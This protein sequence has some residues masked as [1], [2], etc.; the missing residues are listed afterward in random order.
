M[1]ETKSRKISKAE[2]AA[3]L[4]SLRRKRLFFWAVIAIYLPMIWVVLK[5]FHSDKI[6]GMFFG[7]WLVFLVVAVIVSAFA[8]C[9]GCG[10][11]FHM[12]G[13]MPLYLRNCHHCGMHVS[14]DEHKRKER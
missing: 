11:Y 4:K 13:F 10:N 5:I 14:G 1:T 2:F 7:V 6:T 8:R 12:V 3:G 9:P